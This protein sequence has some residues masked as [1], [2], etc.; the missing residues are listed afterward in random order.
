MSSGKNVEVIEPGKQVA[1]REIS[2][3]FGVVDTVRTLQKMM[4]EVTAREVNADTVNAACNCVQNL[5]LTIKT[6][7]QAA[8]YLSDKN[9]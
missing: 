8:R 4:K 5:N 1:L 3:Q 2:E 9:G 7:I 6:A